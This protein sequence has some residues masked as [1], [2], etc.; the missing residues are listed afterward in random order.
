[1]LWLIS[2][3]AATYTY[4]GAGATLPTAWLTLPSGFIMIPS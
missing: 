4:T 2:S 1:M 3:R